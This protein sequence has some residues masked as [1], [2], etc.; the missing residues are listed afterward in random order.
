[1]VRAHVY[2]IETIREAV[3]SS[4]DVLAVTGATATVAADLQAQLLEHGGPADHPDPLIAASAVEH[5]GTVATAEKYV[6]TPKCS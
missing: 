4:M 6:W 2:C 1:V 3:T 5:G